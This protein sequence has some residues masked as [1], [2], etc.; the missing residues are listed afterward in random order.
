[1]RALALM[2]SFGLAIPVGAQQAEESAQTNLLIEA[3]RAGP[4]EVG[5]TL[6]EIF[7]IVGPDQ[8]QL[9]FGSG[10][11]YATPWVLVDL[12]PDEPGAEIIGLLDR[13][14]CPRMWEWN[15]SRLRVL[16]PRFQTADGVGV[17]STL[18]ELQEL[19]WVDSDGQAAP[20]ARE[21]TFP[22]LSFEFEGRKGE[23]EGCAGPEAA[24]RVAE[25]GLMIP[26][27]T[28]RT[29]CASRYE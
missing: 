14:E 27:P 16:D 15:V 28:I 22:L 23:C 8:V 11:G 2:C 12:L 9:G 26:G 24:A 5:M 10:E 25:V 7:M 6:Q 21:G 13:L 18:A 1:M 29:R 17:G 20:R 4:F 19:G 3:G